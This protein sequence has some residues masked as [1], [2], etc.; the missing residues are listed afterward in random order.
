MESLATVLVQKIS[1]G[2]DTSAALSGTS[3]LETISRMISTE[4]MDI[5]LEVLKVF[6][7]DLYFF[8]PAVFGLGR[9]T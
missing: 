7:I 6:L 1:A 9:S 8:F 5:R 2:G 3:N 4:T